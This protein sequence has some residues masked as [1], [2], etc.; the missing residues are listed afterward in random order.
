[1]LRGKPVKTGWIEDR[2]ANDIKEHLLYG[3]K[4]R[5]VSELA[6]GDTLEAEACKDYSG[7]PLLALCYRHKGEIHTDANILLD[8][9]PDD[10]KLL[11]TISEI[12]EQEV[13]R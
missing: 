10:E 8:W 2:F 3:E 6:S 1:M 5:L 12:L 4:D 9:F 11:R 13:G 7:L